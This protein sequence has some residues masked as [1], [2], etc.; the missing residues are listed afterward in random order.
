MSDFEIHSTPSASQEKAEINLSDQSNVTEDSG[1]Q[2]TP[3][4]TKYNAQFNSDV[5]SMLQLLLEQNK[6]MKSDTN[7]KYNE[8][9]EQNKERKSDSD[10]KFNM[11]NS[12]INNKFDELKSEIQELNKCCKNTHETIMTSLNKLEQSVER[13]L[14]L[15][16][17]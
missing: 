10:A 4:S 7:I 3:T 2:L 5:M 14:S 16:H 6:E 9:L 11:Q 8:L 17:I 13:M 15:I 12:I 1:V